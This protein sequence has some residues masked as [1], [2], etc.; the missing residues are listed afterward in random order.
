MQASFTG[1]TEYNSIPA[2]SQGRKVDPLPAGWL[3]FKLEGGD[4]VHL[5]DLRGYSLSGYIANG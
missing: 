4:R 5:P 2:V 1:L 3:A